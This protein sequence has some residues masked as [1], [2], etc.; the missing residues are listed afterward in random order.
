ME[1]LFDRLV[2]KVRRSHE[3]SHE[4]FESCTDYWRCTTECTLDFAQSFND[5]TIPK[6]TNIHPNRQT[7]KPPQLASTTMSSSS[8]ATS[9]TN[10]SRTSSAAP[11]PR[12]YRKKSFLNVSP[13]T[14]EGGLLSVMQEYGQVTDIRIPRNEK[15]HSRGFAFVTFRWHEDAVVAMRELEGSVLD[16]LILHDLRWAAPKKSKTKNSE[17]KKGKGRASSK[18]RGS[19][20]VSPKKNI[21]KSDGS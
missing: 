3:G 9:T 7:S 10:T 15:G 6:T 11:A 20:K 17:D 21:N 14:T 5:L 1:I 16:S 4:L 8:S 2:A 12:R 18:K 19:Q 13:I